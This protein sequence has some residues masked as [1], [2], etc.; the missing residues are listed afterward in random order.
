[1][2]PSDYIG[3]LDD[4]KKDF[5]A[6][7]VDATAGVKN[8]TAALN[9]RKKS[10]ALRDKLKDFRNKSIDNDKSRSEAKSG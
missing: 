2:N 10:M 8:K 9:A 3:F 5:D 4:V 7:I 1:M 6:F